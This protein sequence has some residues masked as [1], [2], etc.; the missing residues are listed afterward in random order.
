[1]KTFM[2]MIIPDKLRLSDKLRIGSSVSNNQ[3]LRVLITGAGRGIGRAIVNELKVSPLKH[4][5]AVTARTESELQDSIKGAS[6]ETLV[7]AADLLDSRSP[8]QIIEKVVKKFGGLD[9]LVLNAGD[10]ISATIEGTDDELW[11]R[12]MEL[13]ATAPFRFIRSV[14]PIMRGQGGGKIVIVA[15][16][17]GLHGAA[18]V[19]AYSA[20]KHAIVGLMRS[21][22]AELSRD[23]IHVNAVCPI[24]VDTPMMQRSVE[25]AAARTGK[26]VDEV[27]TTLASRQPGGRVLTPEEVASAV[28]SYLSVDTS[29]EA[30]YLD[31]SNT[32]GVSR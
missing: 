21:A 24:F 8:S 17:A 26:S 7:I 28:I 3:Q 16:E 27:R 4:K 11:N 30:K 14:A 1:M 29:G 6:G 12:T 19:A 25:A 31:G 9:F 10:G 23:N 5:I 2:G 22:A 32:N 13:N 15:S 18:N 20:S